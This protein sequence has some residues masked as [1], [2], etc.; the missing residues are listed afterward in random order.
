MTIYTPLTI[1]AVKINFDEGFDKDAGLA[2]PKV[3]TA[4]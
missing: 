4:G 2:D 1:A 3:A